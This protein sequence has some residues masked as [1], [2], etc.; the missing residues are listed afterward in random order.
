MELTYT[1]KANSQIQELN[2]RQKAS[3]AAA[4]EVLGLKMTTELDPGQ[5]GFCSGSIL[6]GCK[7]AGSSAVSDH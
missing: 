7:V 5:Q 2:Q 3:K 6:V 1:V 4:K